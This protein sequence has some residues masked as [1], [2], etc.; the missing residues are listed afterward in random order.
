MSSARPIV[1]QVSRAS[2]LSSTG[3]MRASSSRCTAARAPARSPSCSAMRPTRRSPS[4]TSST[5]RPCASSSVTRASTDGDAD[6]L[7][8]HDGAAADDEPLAGRRERGDAEAG[9]H[10]RVAHVVGS[11]AARARCPQDRRR[12]RV[13]RRRL[14][15]GREREDARDRRSSL[16]RLGA[17]GPS[18]GADRLDRDDLGLAQEHRA[19]RAEH[20]DV[21]RARALEGARVLVGDAARERLEVRAREVQRDERHERLRA[22]RD[23]PG[24]H[25]REDLDRRRVRGEGGDADDGRRDG[26]AALDRVTQHARRGRRDVDARR[27]H[28]EELHPRALAPRP[29]RRHAQPAGDDAR[30]GDDGIAVAL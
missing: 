4:A 18:P 13:R 5:L 30:A 20:G 17:R 24:G 8:E 12:E 14:G 23:R 9:V 26:R 22:E 1:S 28:R 29:R 19:A 10:G 21:R 2:P 7:R 25:R 6:L 15:A 27:G 3:S 11:R 16:S